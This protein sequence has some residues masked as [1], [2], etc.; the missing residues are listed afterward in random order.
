MTYGIGNP[1]SDLGHTPKC[2]GVKPI[3]GIPTLP[4]LI[5]NFKGCSKTY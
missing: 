3:N 5:I 4:P 1:D 2:G